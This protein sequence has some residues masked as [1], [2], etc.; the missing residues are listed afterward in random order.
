MI[1][2]SI[3]LLLVAGISWTLAYFISCIPASWSPVCYSVKTGQS[4]ACPNISLPSI[5]FVT[6]E[7]DVVS[8]WTMSHRLATL[9]IHLA[10]S[11]QFII[12]RYCFF[13]HHYY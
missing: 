9:S 10:V 3:G 6:P 1:K 5:P 13:L 7:T 12:E 4:I 11:I 2:A 8:M